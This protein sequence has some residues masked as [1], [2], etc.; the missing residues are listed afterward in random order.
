MTRRA[1]LLTSIVPALI[2]VCVVLLSGCGGDS[3]NPSEPNP[4]CGLDV[5]SLAF[6]SVTVGESRD[7]TFTITNTGSGTLA[8]TVSD[9]C[10]DFSIITN[11]T[12]SLEGGVSTT[13]TVRFLPQSAGAK[14]CTINT[15]ASQCAGLACTGTGVVPDVCEVHPASIDF[16]TVTVGTSRDTTF[17]IANIGGSTLSGSVTATCDEYS[18]VFGSGN[19]SLEP[20]QQHA[21]TV[22]FA[23]ATAG[24]KT[25]MIE[26]GTSCA[27]VPC[28]GVGELSPTCDVSVQTLDFGTVEVGAHKD[29][30]FTI[31]N[32][33]G[34]MLSGEV[35]AT[36]D[37]FS[38]VGETQYNLAASQS[39]TFTV[40]F[41]P[42]AAGLI[43]A[44]VNLDSEF[45]PDIELVGYGAV[46]PL[47][48]VTPAS[49]DLG[50]V[51]VAGG[52]DR[53]F[54]IRNI[55]TE[56]LSGTVS[57]PCSDFA[58]IGEA[59]YSLGAGEIDTFTVRFSPAHLGAGGCAIET[60][61]GA[62]GDISAAGCGV[63]HADYYVLGSHGSDINLGTSQAP[64][65]TITH[66]ITSAGPDM[67]ICVL[68]GT[69]D[70]ANG[71]TFPIRLDEGQS[72]VGDVATKGAGAVPTVIY[73]SGDADPAPGDNNLAVLVVADGCTVSGLNFD[74]AYAV[75]TYGIYLQNATVSISDNTLGRTT[76][77]NLYGGVFAFGPGASIITRND[78]LTVS[79][80]VKGGTLSGGL[81]V[82]ANLF[83]T[84]SIPMNLTA[85]S[86]VIIR[87]N[88][89][90]GGDQLAIQIFSGAP[91]IENNV[92]NRPGHFGD[93]GA[94]RCYSTN[95]SPKVRGNTFTCVRGVS[96]ADAAVPD[97]GTVADP[98]N[99]DFSGVSEAAIYDTGTS[100]VGAVGNTWSVT[101]PVCGTTIVVTGGGSVTWGAG[102]GESC[103]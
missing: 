89:F 4:I 3:G 7:L 39:A 47:C 23:P 24:T 72:L 30:S 73:G 58:I 31:T 13:V 96:I 21:V 36:Q 64:F 91:L 95:S 101:P 86:G 25:C 32:T 69:Y 50:Y 44:A 78:F 26:T 11:A 57:S 9:T 15:G 48:E 63:P 40:R 100:S 34:G 1:A 6:G 18:L 71:E 29:A 22:R 12:Y 56:T 51:E 42:V 77:P 35:Y 70:V 75:G 28:T 38:I 80:G 65:K 74:A 83:Q 88:T 87:G 33:G 27:S 46:A 97:L 67:I 66:A 99:N 102:A 55:G 19:Y 16:G 5:Q 93:F 59:T 52:A 84:P 90:A 45:C 81:L 41:T 8:G 60:G 10:A 82:E 54:T 53:T 20:A 94:I 49:I 76:T 14:A 85:A 43:Q 79:Y 103:P 98:G 68:P 2:L 92:F 17:Y 61:A 62:C 37:D